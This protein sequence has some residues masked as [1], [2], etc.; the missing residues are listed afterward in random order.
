MSQPC[1]NCGTM[2][3]DSYRFCSNCGALLRPADSQ[4]APTAPPPVPPPVP[5]N[6][7]PPQ[8]PPPAPEAGTTISMSEPPAQPGAP[9]YVVKTSPEAE[10]LAA[11]APTTPVGGFV[12]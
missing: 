1:P 2:N 5:V 12:P 7:D 4:P 11:Q 10:N 8:P 6:V 9:A 3:L